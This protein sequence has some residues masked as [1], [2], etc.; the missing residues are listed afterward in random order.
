MTPL[1]IKWSSLALKMNRKNRKQTEHL[2]SEHFF[3]RFVKLN[4]RIS[5][6][7][8]TCIFIFFLLIHMSKFIRIQSK[9]DEIDPIL[10]ST[11][12]S[13]FN[14]LQFTPQQITDPGSN[15]DQKEKSMRHVPLFDLIWP[16]FFYFWLKSDSNSIK[17]NYSERPKTGRLVFGVFETCPVPKSS[18]F[19]TTSD[20]RT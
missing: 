19:Q 4:V 6:L 7:Y 18:G 11:I 3:V 16:F 2:K 1:Y 14:G 5:V 12:W 20:N 15:Q 9:M 17:T 10:R 8:C 13:F